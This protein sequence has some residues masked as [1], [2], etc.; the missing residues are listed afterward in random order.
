M[1]SVLLGIVARRRS[2]KRQLSDQ[3]NNFEIGESA[4]ASKEV[5]LL[6]SPPVGTRHR[7]KLNNQEPGKQAAANIGK[8]AKIS[9]RKARDEQQVTIKVSHAFLIS[10][11][12]NSCENKTLELSDRKLIAHSRKCVA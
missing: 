4:L 12:E 3:S 5:L 8:I 2:E 9:D 1:G 10:T 7:H 6:E 11:C